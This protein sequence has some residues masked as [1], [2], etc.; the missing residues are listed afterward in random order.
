MFAAHVDELPRGVGTSTPEDVAHATVRAIE[1]DQ[2]EVDVAPL[3][4]RAA[5]LL[6]GVAPDLL[7]L[8]NRRTGTAEIADRTRRS[9]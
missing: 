7:G 1:Q 6:G 2:G 3:P 8:L 9:G 5:G 4:V